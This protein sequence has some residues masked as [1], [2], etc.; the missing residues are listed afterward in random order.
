MNNCFESAQAKIVRAI[1]QRRSLE[2][3]LAEYRRRE[4]YRTIV[5]SDRKVT[6][7]I[8][9]PPPIEI[10]VIAGEVIYQLRSALDHIF[11]L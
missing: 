9:E 1:K 2:N 11:S 8:T 7:E 3:C 4:P 6:L 10:S 5:H